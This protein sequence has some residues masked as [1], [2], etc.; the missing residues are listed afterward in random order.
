MRNERTIFELRFGEI[1]NILP[2]VSN[3]NGSLF[4]VKYES[5]FKDSLDAYLINNHNSYPLVWLIPPDNIKYNK[6]SNTETA[7]VTFFIA[8]NSQKKN[9]YNTQV[10]YTDFK[11]GLN[12]IEKN[13]THALMSSSISNMSSEYK[14][15]RVIN[16]NL[17]RNDSLN[18]VD[19]WNYIKI[20]AEIQFNGNCLRKINF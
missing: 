19:I 13:I 5:G 7:N 16:R 10:L 18:S 4:D 17:K 20:S 14:V 12:E 9:K 15:S 8:M 6:D 11:I 2:Q 3:D 1:V